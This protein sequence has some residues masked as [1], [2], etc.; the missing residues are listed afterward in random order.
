MNTLTVNDSTAE[1]KVVVGP[2]LNSATKKTK[3]WSVRGAK[4]RG[5][6]ATP[7]DM[8]AISGV[9]I[10]TADMDESSSGCSYR[11]AGEFIA[12][13][14]LPKELKPVTFH[15]GTGRWCDTQRGVWVEVTHALFLP[16]GDV[17]AKFAN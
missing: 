11:A 7:Q 12:P 9:T 13:S 16:N 4:Q 8:V 5:S 10:I 17:L 15:P 2:N 1:G 6:Q 3:R 14:E